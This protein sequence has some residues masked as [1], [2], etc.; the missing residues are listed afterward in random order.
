MVKGNFKKNLIY[1]HIFQSGM[2]I[3]NFYAK[4][5]YIIVTILS[6]WRGVEKKMIENSSPLRSFHAFF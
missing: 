4:K 1:I 5:Y 6:G 3:D 2:L